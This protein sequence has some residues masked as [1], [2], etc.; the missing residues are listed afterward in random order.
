M[1]R[2]VL[3]SGSPERLGV[4]PRGAGVNVAVFSGHAD[5]IEFCLFD[6]AGEREVRRVKLPERSGDIFHGLI[7]DVPAGA[8]YGLRAYG[9]YAPA[10][11]HRFNPSKLL[12]DPY[13]RAIDRPFK[14]H[15]SMFSTVPGSTLPDDAD[16]SG[17]MPKAIVVPSS[18]KLTPHALVPWDRTVLYELHVR[19]FTMQ[20]DAI[21]V[22]LRG[23]FGGLGHPAS[24]EHLVKL[25]VT[26]VEIM[27]AAAWI[28]ERHLAA[29]G[30]QNY[31][32]Y[33]T[34]A[35]MTPDPRL[36]PGGWDE[37][38]TTVA[39]L[40]KAGIE[41]IAD[42]VLN[43]TGEGHALGPT[44]SMRGLDNASYYRLLPGNPAGYVDDAGCGNV[45]A[46]DRPPVV[47]LAMDTLRCWAEL[48]G[49]HGFRFD[50]APVLGRRG[51]G[52][53]PAAPLLSAISQDPL[54]RELKL[55][56]EPWDVGAGGYQVG[57][58]PGGWG[59]WNDHFRDD[60]RRFWRGDPMGLGE[61]ATRLAASADLFARKNRPSRSVNFVVAHDGF[62]LADLVSYTRRAN[63]ANGEDNRDGTEDNRSWNNGV[64]G[65]NDDPAVRAARLRDQRALL[66][67]LLLARG[68]PMLA[69]GAELGHSQGG[70]NNAYAQD[71]ETSWIDWAA[72]DES[73]AAWTARL[74]A[75][76]RDNPAF[77][78]DRFLIGQPIEGGFL[79]DVEWRR[80]D[81]KALEIADWETPYGSALV[82]LLSSTAS[83]GCDRAAL[84][85]NRGHTPVA[86][87]LPDARDGYEWRSL[88]NSGD[89]DDIGGPVDDGAILTGRSI[90]V[91]AE[92]VSRSHQ[93]VR[94]GRAE[95]LE[96]LAR[97]AGI[98]AEWSAVDRTRHIVGDDTKRALLAS[99]HLPAATE[100]EAADTLIRFA[101]E[102]DR[103]PLPSALTIWVD[104]PAVLDLPLERDL[105]RRSLLLTVTLESGETRSVSVGAMNGTLLPGKAIDGREYL[106]WRITLPALPI[107]RHVV[108]R[109]DAPGATCL[110]TVA[111]RRGFLPAMLADG[112]R[113]FGITAQLYSM[114]GAADQGIGDFSVLADLAE[115]TAR[116]GGSAVII[117][118]LH[119][120]FAADRGRASP[121]QPNDRR[122][123]DPI[124]LDVGWP[125]DGAHEKIFSALSATAVVDYP[126][127]WAA[128]SAILERRFA[129]FDAT[130]A[131]DFAAFVAAGG[132]ALRRYAI[133]E[134]IAETRPGE[135]WK[136][137]PIGLSD[138]NS[139]AVEAFAQVNQGRVRFHQYLQYLC[140]RQL[141]EAARRAGAA[142]LGLGLMRD[143]AIG[144]A[145]DGAEVWAQPDMFVS[146]VSVG[147]PPDPLALNGQIWGL[148]P[149]DP[150]GMARTGFSAFAGLLAANMRHARGLRIDHVMGVSR[151]F[152]VPDGAD[153]KDGAYVAYPFKD[154]LG[155]LTVESSRAQCLVIGEDL[156]TVP[157]GLREPLAAADVQSYRV[158]FLERDG[159]GFKPPE[160][161]RANALA[162]ISTHDLPTFIGWWE[163]ADLKERH[164]LGIIPSD[165]IAEAVAI[166]ADEKAAL[167]DALVAEALL[168]PLE[169][170]VAP[171]VE[172][173]M[174]AAHAYVARSQAALVMA[175][176]DDLAGELIAVNLPG[177]SIERANW[178]RKIEIPVSDLLGTPTAQAILEA[179]REARGTTRLRKSR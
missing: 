107:G 54:L 67:I 144:A 128:K 178:R 153:G 5:A 173:I 62:T 63:F 44:L 27:P 47:R 135:L 167:I 156:G 108:R 7:G 168:P 53:D 145:P 66:A 151:L 136:A 115:A 37:V 155:Q 130:P 175:Q 40:A 11:G 6:A 58:F 118:P 49:V 14:L 127:V 163:A 39:A 157:E 26:S 105:S 98:A 129:E 78:E 103:R 22:S 35:F 84:A 81:G 114:R 70:N 73:L 109:E 42:I 43:H 20:R 30:L 134:A 148:P 124:Y 19:G 113:A 87:A 170:G 61:L 68:T 142:G 32:G 76:R 138:V 77:H 8:R 154:L 18:P 172:Q 56:A 164:A 41:T 38:R 147:A 126:A 13:A 64:E 86:I 52:F 90:L 23:T 100:R 31:W 79:P 161:Y 111:P 158:L 95:V 116:E 149:L 34:V 179:L 122:F 89:A 10:A 141:S 110:L 45:L 125:G 1:L 15:P 143:L 97:A 137:W 123:L 91:L 24:I 92:T 106:L 176:T 69:M 177:T 60:V 133:F 121:Y 4:T 120:L 3:D 171:P 165:G 17:A 93:P 160:S 36:A 162:C 174:A 96:R 85:I 33:N 150:H 169:T 65:Q 50:L 21:P 16:S 88:A 51:D 12:I 2:S 75:I 71:N 25:G 94:R 28:E 83:A 104:E 101:D 59:E 152:W 159:I 119:A 117:N 55:I 57:A 131:S 99:L 132:S 80:P 166:R 72:A 48:G 140:D 146:G 9:P 46:L 102:H 112:G 139:P 82:M 29:L 74:I